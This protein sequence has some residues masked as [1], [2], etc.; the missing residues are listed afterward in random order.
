VHA[1]RV[2]GASDPR[3]VL[4]HI[5]PNVTV[6]LIVIGTLQVARMILSEASLSYLGLGIPPPDPSWGSMIADGRNV[7]G[8]A[9]W[10]ATIPGIAIMLCVL[11]I[12]LLGD[13]LRDELDP[14]LRN[15]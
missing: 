14:Y 15:R 1:A 11:G 5:L 8:L 6:S 4:R 9:W 3:I 2:V 12:N 7:I 13:F 10:V